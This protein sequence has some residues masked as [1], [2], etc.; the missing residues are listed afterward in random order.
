MRTARVWAKISE[1]ASDALDHLAARLG[2]SSEEIAGAAIE[3]CLMIAQ[4]G[5]P[6]GTNLVN[7]LFLMRHGNGHQETE[8]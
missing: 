4:K 2:M 3:A 7:L 8:Q 6:M 1:H 5:E